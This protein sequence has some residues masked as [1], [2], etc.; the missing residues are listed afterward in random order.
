[1]AISRILQSFNLRP[2]LRF[3]HTQIIV[4]HDMNAPDIQAVE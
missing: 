4:G 3:G 2:L 1:M